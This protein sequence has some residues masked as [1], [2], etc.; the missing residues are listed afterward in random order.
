[1]QTPEELAANDARDFARATFLRKYPAD[2]KPHAGAGT[3]AL[4]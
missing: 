4:T 3:S 1:M 2:F